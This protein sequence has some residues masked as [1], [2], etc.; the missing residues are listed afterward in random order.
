M[1][2]IALGADHAGFAL[3]EQIKAWLGARGAQIHDYGTFSLDSVDYP[4]FATR[5]AEA[6]T[7]GTASRGVLVCGTG[8]GMAM[9]ANKFPGIRAAVCGDVHT[10]RMSREHNDANVLALGARVT[11]RDVAVGILEAWLETAFVGGRH[12]RRLEKIAAIEEK[13]THAPSR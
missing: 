12:A 7:S 9:V 10:A 11:D 1:S 13:A 3:K 6:V 5:V 8:L 2:V 4:D